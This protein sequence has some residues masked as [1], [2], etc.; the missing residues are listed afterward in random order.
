[1]PAYRLELFL[2]DGQTAQTLAFFSP[3]DEQALVWGSSA[4][5]FALHRA[6]RAAEVWEDNRLVGKLTEGPQQ[7]Q[8]YNSYDCP[9]CGADLGTISHAKSNA[10]AILTVQLRK[11]G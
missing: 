4:M 11:S 2:A 5:E 1:M 10:W 8:P 9:R 6:Y 3:D 7:E